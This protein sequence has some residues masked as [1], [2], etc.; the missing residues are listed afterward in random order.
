MA[1]VATAVVGIGLLAAA[2]AA[3]SAGTRT[4]SVCGLWETTANP[5]LYVRSGPGVNYPIKGSPIPYHS[6]ITGNCTP[7]NGFYFVLDPR[8][9]T[10]HWANGRYLCTSIP[11]CP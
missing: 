11:N 4:P 2:P 6:L 9:S 10:Y 1:M 5:V 3:A 7:T 8:D